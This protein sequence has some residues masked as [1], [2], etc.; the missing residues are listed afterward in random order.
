[1]RARDHLY[2][3]KLV[4]IRGLNVAFLHSLPTISNTLILSGRFST[5]Y[6]CSHFAFGCLWKLIGESVMIAL[7]YLPPLVMHFLEAKY[8]ACLSD[9]LYYLK[10]VSMHGLDDVFLHVL[11]TISN[12]LNLSGWFSTLCVSFHFAFGSF[13]CGT[14]L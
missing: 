8:Y 12:V 4:S 9:Y 6:L 1:M 13:S 7:T 11:P 10:L 3:V 14:H 2:Y 5:Q